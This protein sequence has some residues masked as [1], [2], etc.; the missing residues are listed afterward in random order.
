MKLTKQSFKRFGIRAQVFAAF[1]LFTAVIVAL[2]WIFQI[3]LL[4]TFYKTIKKNEIKNTASY[5]SKN[6][7]DNNLVEILAGVTKNT[8]V[9]VMITDEHGNNIINVSGMYDGLFEKLTPNKCARIYAE[10]KANGGD[11]L[12]SYTT[13]L[14]GN[15][16]FDRAFINDSQTF[17]REQNTPEGIIYL[18]TV[19]TEKGEERLLILN[20]MVTPVDS[21]VDTLKIQLWCLTIVMVLLSA[22]L[23]WVLSRKISGP[24]SAINQNAKK[25]ASGS[26]DAS[27]VPGGS[28]ETRELAETLNYAAAELSKVEGLRRE[29]IANVSHDLRTPLTMISGFSEV[30]R[31]IPGENTPENAQI[32]IDEATRLKNLVSDLL[33]ISKLEVGQVQLTVTRVNLTANI[34]EILTRYD[35][36]VEYSFNFYHGDDVFV[37]GDALK[38]SQVVYNLV[39]NA[40]TYTGAD[41]QVFL[42]QTVDAG[43][44]KIEI[45]DTG[46]GIPTDQ[47]KNIWDRY[48]K[49][50]KEHKR[51]Q[52]G[53]GLGLSIVKNIV[54][55][56]AGSCGVV[57]E[58]GKGSTFWF[59]LPVA[60]NISPNTKE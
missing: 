50:D 20:T 59:T 29:L 25:L 51:A 32:I 46:D 13:W 57:S 60:E 41:K 6:L 5:I 48:Y 40:I 8:G 31:D 23:A 12:E 17:G 11:F 56:H 3:S 14:T 42:T 28:R 30:M 34:R 10:T 58:E 26:Y 43:L 35:K 53:T 44:V 7:Y 15:G 54:E 37:S 18:R 16:L 36:L 21:T 2:L 22:L 38:L 45:R 1:T 33:D 19:T 47:L 9:D 52:I 39:N 24:I 49:V 55:L 27:F 4:N